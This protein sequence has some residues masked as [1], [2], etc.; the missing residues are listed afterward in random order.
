MGKKPRRCPEIELVEM[1]RNPRVPILSV[2]CRCNSIAEH[3]CDSGLDSYCLVKPVI[4]GPIRP[5]VT[6]LHR[7]GSDLVKV[8]AIAET[9]APEPMTR[10]LTAIENRPPLV[11]DLLGS[12]IGFS[13]NY[14]LDEAFKDA[15]QKLRLVPSPASD[16]EPSMVDVVSMGAVYGGFSGYSRMFVR[17]EQSRI[18][19]ATSDRSK[20]T[21]RL[22]KSRH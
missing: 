18:L 9:A 6:F 12:A 21:D 1:T 20:K 7:D 2:Q 14:S 19:A 8:E 17:V 11:P 10:S 22:G 3:A 13:Q 4:A 15:L 16:A 5:Y